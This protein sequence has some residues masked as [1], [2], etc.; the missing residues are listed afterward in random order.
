MPHY[1]ALVHK[2]P[3]SDYGVMLPDFPGCVSA[4]E[5]FDEAVREAADALS[6][7]AAGM[8]RDGDP[9]PPPRSLD[10]IKAAAEDWIVWADAVVVAI[11]LLPPSGRAV[12]VNITLDE[13]LLAEIDAA[14]T[15]RSAFLAVAA[16]QA[17]DAASA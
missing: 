10:A 8:R 1:I 11:P 4:G 7:H 17:L 3:D 9:I 15:N 13:R 14:T 2:D 6:G 12:R 16:R 5:T